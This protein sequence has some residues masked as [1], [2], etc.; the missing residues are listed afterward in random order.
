MHWTFPKNSLED[1]ISIAKAIEDKN[2]GNPMKADILAKAVGF[3][4]PTDWRFLDLLKSAN[5]YGLVSGSGQH[6][7]VQLVDIGQDVVAPGS[8]GDRKSAL[9]RAFRNV[10]DFKR[11]EGFYGTKWIPEDEYL[12]IH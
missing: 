4:K 3:N 5:L 10:E 9:L 2:G 12:S 1:A 6:A 11:V 7:L 8:S